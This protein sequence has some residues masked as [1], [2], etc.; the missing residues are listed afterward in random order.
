M[1]EPRPFEDLA[2]SGLL[3]L[4]NASVFH[5]R[6]FAL[7]LKVKDGKAIGWSLLGDGSE[8]WYFEGTRNDKFNAVA[9]TFRQVMLAA[10]TADCGTCGGTGAVGN[11]GEMC[12]ACIGSSEAAGDG[13]RP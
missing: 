1:T 11:E 5:P 4:I 13:D 8:P 12:P 3:W 10:G 9:A 6:G 7:A 2:T